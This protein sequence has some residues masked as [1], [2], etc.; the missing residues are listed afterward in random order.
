M[1]PKS[2][3]T[4]PQPPKHSKQSPQKVSMMLSHLL[5]ALPMPPTAVGKTR[6]YEPMA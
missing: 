1:Q 4:H 5:V 6:P 2:Q 3:P